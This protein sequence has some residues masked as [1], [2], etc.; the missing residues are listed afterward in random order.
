MKKIKHPW[1]AR[2]LDLLKT[3][4]AE[5]GPAPLVEMMPYRTECSIKRKA[6]RLDIRSPINPPWTPSEDQTV[7]ELYPLF[8]AVVVAFI[9]GKSQ[10]AIHHRARH[11]RMSPSL[12]RKLKEG[13]TI[14]RVWSEQEDALIRK[15]YPEGGATEVLKRL[16]HPRRRSDVLDRAY[17]LGVPYLNRTCFL[18]VI[19]LNKTTAT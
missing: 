3:Y 15:H 17:S 12:N 7:I 19:P 10:N 16:D 11:L 8:G 18:S 13:L 6:N 9:L 2:D 14:K 5:L 1:T 4:Y